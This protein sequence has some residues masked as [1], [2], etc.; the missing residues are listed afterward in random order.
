[1][2]AIY[3]LFT[4]NMIIIIFIVFLLK[5]IFRNTT[6]WTLNNNKSINQSHMNNQISFYFWGDSEVQY[7]R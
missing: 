7:L 4:E 3:I 1:M 2:N 5:P 6:R